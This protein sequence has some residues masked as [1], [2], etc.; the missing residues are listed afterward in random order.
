MSKKRTD[1]PETSALRTAGG[2]VYVL[3][4]AGTY[5]CQSGTRLLVVQRGAT[6]GSNAD[7]LYAELFATTW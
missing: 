4:E 2:Q 7:G 1:W 3:S 5:L 6:R